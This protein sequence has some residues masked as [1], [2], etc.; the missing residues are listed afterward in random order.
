M[1]GIDVCARVSPKAGGANGA[2]IQLAADLNNMHVI[3]QRDQPG[4]Y[5]AVLAVIDPTPTP[6]MPASPCVRLRPGS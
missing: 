3:D 1:D 5:S 2:P 6:T 4:Q